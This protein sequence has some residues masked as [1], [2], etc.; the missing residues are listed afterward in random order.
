MVEIDSVIGE[1]LV[2]IEER[3]HEERG[4]KSENVTAALRY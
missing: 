4:G 1:E 2:G 3:R